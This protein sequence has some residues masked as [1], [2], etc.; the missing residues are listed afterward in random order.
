MFFLFKD[1]KLPLRSAITVRVF[2]GETSEERVSAEHALS[3]L[4]S[5]QQA[6]K[7]SEYHESAITQRDALF[8]RFCRYFYKKSD[9]NGFDFFAAIY[10][11]N[12]ESLTREFALLT[13]GK[14]NDLKMT[15]IAQLLEDYNKF[16]AQ[17]LDEAAGKNVPGLDN[18]NW[19]ALF[20][21]IK[22]LI[23][24]ARTVSGVIAAVAIAAEL[25]SRQP[26]IAEFTLGCLAKLEPICHEILTANSSFCL[27]NEVG[28]AF[29]L[30][31]MRESLIKKL[32]DYLKTRAEPGETK[33]SGSYLIQT[34]QPIDRGPFYNKRLQDARI[35]LASHLLIQLRFM[36]HQGQ[37]IDSPMQLLQMLQQAKSENE[38]LFRF[39]GRVIDKQGD[40]ANLLEEMH[41]E[42]NKVYDWHEVNQGCFAI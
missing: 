9:L 42:L 16:K 11:A 20:L 1:K 34:Y 40:L 4:Y 29:K 37:A 33:R 23:A 25:A 2:V 39:Y 17:N 31:R 26:K 10:R 12:T 35:E 36:R 27:G 19:E 5:Y 24:S 14:F 28:P 7:N 38:Y 21:R 8:T 3:L 30:E 6:F 22:T 41:Q 15:L 32:E 13:P 18:A